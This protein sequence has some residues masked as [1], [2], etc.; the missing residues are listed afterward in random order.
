M[1]TLADRA[2][3]CSELWDYI[4]YLQLGLIN[5]ELWMLKV[6]IKCSALV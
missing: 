6:W 5:E 2:I 4:L 1:M 3:S